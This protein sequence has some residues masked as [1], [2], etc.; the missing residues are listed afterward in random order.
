MLALTLFG[1]GVDM[2]A[3][4]QILRNVTHHNAAHIGQRVWDCPDRESCREDRPRQ[5]LLSYRKASV[6]AGAANQ[7]ASE[8]KSRSLD[9]SLTLLESADKMALPEA[10]KSLLD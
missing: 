8:E 9:C 1:M 3:H 2:P 4:A 5:R 7:L 6:L 10:S